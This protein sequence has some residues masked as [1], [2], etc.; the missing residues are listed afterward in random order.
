M[1][2]SNQ[3]CGSISLYLCP[4]RHRPRALLLMCL[5]RASS[6]HI[7]GMPQAGDCGANTGSNGN[8]LPV[9]FITLFRRKPVML[10]PAIGGSPEA[11]ES[12]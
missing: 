12:C 7:R 4:S 5:H 6:K 10:S 8:E 2:S 1:E 9:D 11:P 3:D